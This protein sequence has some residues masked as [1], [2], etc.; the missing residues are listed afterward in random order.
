VEADLKNVVLHAPE[1]IPIILTIPIKEFNPS[2]ENF[3]ATVEEALET[4]GGLLFD[5]IKA[6]IDK[7][8]ELIIELLNYLGLAIVSMFPAHSGVFARSSSSQPYGTFKKWQKKGE[9]L[10]KLRNDIIEGKR[11]YIPWLD[12]LILE[13]EPHAGVDNKFEKLR[14]SKAVQEIFNE[15]KKRKR[16]LLSYYE[17]LYKE[18]PLAMSSVRNKYQYTYS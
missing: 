2:G 12:K 10:W 4:T 7:I 11:D 18:S 5:F 16:I 6:F 14:H 1:L 17:N 15:S 3:G 8:F 13:L 9:D